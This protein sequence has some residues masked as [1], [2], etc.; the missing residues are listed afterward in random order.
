MKSKRKL[1]IAKKM[2]F[3]MP[4]AK[5]AFSIAH[6]LL[7][8]NEKGLLPLTPFVLTVNDRPDPSLPNVVQFS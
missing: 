4:K 6:V 5:L 7:V 8:F 1:V 2:I 3:M